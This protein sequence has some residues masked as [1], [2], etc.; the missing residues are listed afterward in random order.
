MHLETSTLGWLLFA[1]L[2]FLVVSALMGDHHADGGGDVGHGGDAQ[3]SIITSE[4]FNIRNL[5]LLFAGFSAASLIAR[6]ANV[7][8]FG[9]NIAGIC[10]AFALVAFGTLL[11]RTIRRQE[12]NSIMSNTGLV[13][14]NATVTTSIPEIGYGEIVLQNASG[15]ATTLVAEA[16]GKAISQGTK[17]SIVAVSGNYATVTTTT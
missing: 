6:N 13:G 8:E 7:G 5:A 9:T 1:S 3:H 4:L 16:S 15:V 2:V 14:K 11:F 17:V 12:S 10:G